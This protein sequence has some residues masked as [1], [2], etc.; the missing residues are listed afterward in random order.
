MMTTFITEGGEGLGKGLSPT[1]EHGLHALQSARSAG[2]LTTYEF[3]EELLKLF[4]QGAAAAAPT[5]TTPSPADSTSGGLGA[6]VATATARDPEYL[7][8]PSPIS[9]RDVPGAQ[10]PKPCFPRSPEMQLGARDASMRRHNLFKPADYILSPSP[11][12][13]S[14]LLR[15]RTQTSAHI[16]AH[17]QLTNL[18]DAPRQYRDYHSRTCPRCPSAIG[19]SS[20]YLVSCPLTKQAEADAHRP[21][22]NLLRH[23]HL[24][25]CSQLGGFEFST[26]N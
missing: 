23:L 17:Q 7:C 11:T 26:L 18:P 5:S 6:Q 3:E 9:P 8:G 14:A 4:T 1:L 22:S 20:H 2:W 10:V 12:S 15:L 21:I 13:A 25:P 19:S 16:I 24:P